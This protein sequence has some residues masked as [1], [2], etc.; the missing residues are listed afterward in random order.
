MHLSMKYFYI[1]GCVG[2]MKS[3][4]CYCGLDISFANIISVLF[5]ARI[6]VKNDIHVSSD[7]PVEIILLDQFACFIDVPTGMQLLKMLSCWSP[8][9]CPAPLCKLH[10]MM[11]TQALT[12]PISCDVTTSG[13]R[14]GLLSVMLIT[15][16]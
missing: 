13:Q 15:G 5:A 4:T 8:V 1:N 7:N 6:E 3:A 9:R 11:I 12:E 16:F 14:I 10:L 2:C